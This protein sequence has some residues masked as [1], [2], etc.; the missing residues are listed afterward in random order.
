MTFPGALGRP[1]H[2][3]AAHQRTFVREPSAHKA[4]LLTGETAD[5][6]RIF[7]SFFLV[8]VFQPEHCA[9]ANMAAPSSK[10]AAYDKYMEQSGG[11]QMLGQAVVALSKA[12]L[13][14]EDVQPAAFLR[15]FFETGKSASSVASA[16]LSEKDRQQV[17]DYMKT[18]GAY[19]LLTKALVALFDAPERP[20][21]PGV[22][23]QAF[24]LKE[25]PP[26]A[27]PIPSP[28][29]AA[30]VVAEKTPSA[31]E[32]AA[33]EPSAP[34]AAAAEPTPEAAAAEPAPPAPE[35][36]AA[37]PAAP[38]DGGGTQDAGGADAA[39]GGVEG[40]EGAGGEGGAGDDSAEGGA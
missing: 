17:G 5:S 8:V 12:A 33:A 29:P 15:D 7:H 1:P 36:A 6:G 10:K 34:E 9:L 26:P 30:A 38:E 19:D 2:R 27:E 31:P 3:S 14:D 32:A 35:A 20:P 13:A 16:E 18:S 21:N 25:A 24:F 28:P 39:E 11:K 40:A 4:R 37:E 22:H 23:F